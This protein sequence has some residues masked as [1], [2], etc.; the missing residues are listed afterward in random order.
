LGINLDFDLNKVYEEVLKLQ[1]EP[2]NA[3]A[4]MA[5]EHTQAFISEFL[6][7]SEKFV[8][9]GTK[10]Y[11]DK[12]NRAIILCRVFNYMSLALHRQA[13]IYSIQDKLKEQEIPDSNDLEKIKR[14]KENISEINS[15]VQNIKKNCKHEFVSAPQYVETM[16]FDCTPKKKCLV[17]D[18]VLP[19]LV[20]DEEK[21]KLI[22]NWYEDMELSITEHEIESR[23]NGFNI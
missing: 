22:K 12:A 4:K 9:D 2:M 18:A 23:K 15:Q 21:I 19:I 20:T 6:N 11:E 13:A 5:Y 1:T 10:T 17:C 7:L 14:L 8:Y 3:T 16:A